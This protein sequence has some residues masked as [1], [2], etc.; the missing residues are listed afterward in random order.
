MGAREAPLVLFTLKAVAAA[1][2]RAVDG[3]HGVVEQIRDL[4]GRPA[5]DVAQHDGHAL[6]RW[7]SCIAVT[8]ASPIRSR[9]STSSSG[10]S[11]GEGSS[12]SSWSG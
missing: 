1:L 5:E 10:P 8:K 7:Q 12:S 4:A 11:A 9:C 6:L 3:R 2:Q